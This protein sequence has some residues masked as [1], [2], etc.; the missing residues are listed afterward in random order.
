MVNHS[1]CVPLHFRALQQLGTMA[2]MH[3][4]S[5]CENSM[6]VVLVGGYPM[7]VDVS[8]NS[9]VAPLTSDNAMSWTT[10]SSFTTPVSAFWWDTVGE[11]TSVWNDNAGIFQQCFRCGGAVFHRLNLAVVKFVV[12]GIFQE[13]Y[14]NGYADYSEEGQ[15][16]VQSSHKDYQTRRIILVFLMG[17]CAVTLF[18]CIQ[19]A[20]ELKKAMEVSAR[21]AACS[22]VI[23]SKTPLL[24]SLPYEGVQDIPVVAVATLK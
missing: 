7:T 11:K 5:D 22:A 3:A 12:L 16:P 4:T 21:K 15:L 23:T 18:L 13:S 1:C 10:D 19:Q 6:P 9:F 14:S 8:D 2:N 20:R 17:I 24:G